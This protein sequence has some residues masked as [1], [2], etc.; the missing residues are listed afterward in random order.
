[1]TQRFLAPHLNR[2]LLPTSRLSASSE[3]A[4]HPLAW[5]RDQSSGKAWRS[6][7][8]WTFV[9]GFNN[10]GSHDR[11]GIYT[12]TITGGTYGATGDEVS[13]AVVAALQASDP[14]VIWGCSRDPVTCKFTIT[15]NIPVAFR[16]AT[17]GP[18]SWWRCL[19]FS[20]VADRA[21]A[22]V[23][24][25]EAP[26]YQ[27][28]H[29]IGLDLVAAETV[30]GYALVWNVDPAGT[31]CY[32][33]GSISSSIHAAAS[34][35]S[36]PPMVAQG[37]HR[38]QN[39]TIPSRRYYGLAVD[40]VTD[41]QGWVGLSNLHFGGYVGTTHS[42]TFT[43]YQLDPQDLSGLEMAVSGAHT[44]TSRPVRKVWTIGW[45]ALEDAD[46][47]VLRALKQACPRGKNFWVLFDPNDL[48]DVEYVMLEAGPTERMPTNTLYSPAA[49]LLQVL[50]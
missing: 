8:G 3:D 33:G 41:P 36:S 50:P 9:G 16:C 4:A 24:T 13:L 23:H 1:M 35:T 34:A 11:G 15:S 49:T 17:D 29:F 39:N 18:A 47:D 12:S 5:L 37:S 30:P 44:R 25:A 31:D 40:A 2:L 26:A 10:T 42:W 48:T 6:R 21:S 46:M 20:T 38:L 43:D 14:G 28:R 19:G 22:T 27:S 7:L 32:F 45:D